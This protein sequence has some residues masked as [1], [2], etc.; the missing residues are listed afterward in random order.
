VECYECGA[1]APY[2]RSDRQAIAEWN[3]RPRPDLAEIERLLDEL[4]V[5]YAQF[6]LSEM[7]F[8]KLEDYST[9][10]KL[11][12]EAHNYREA[13]AALMKAIGE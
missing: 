8:R 12:Q 10:Q 6:K 4:I 3:T 1:T 7:E 9:T 5:V 11:I 2:V 13:K